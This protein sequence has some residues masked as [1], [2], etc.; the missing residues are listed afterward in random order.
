MFARVTPGKR[1]YC[2]FVN[3]DCVCT[4]VMTV[5]V[6]GGGGGGD[7]GGGVGLMVMTVIIMIFLVRQW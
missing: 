6:K 7:R 3:G 1:V 5:V 4:A 2:G